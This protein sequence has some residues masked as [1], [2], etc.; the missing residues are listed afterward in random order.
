MHAE[1]RSLLEGQWV[2]WVSPGARSISRV[3]SLVKESWGQHMSSLYLGR[4]SQ[5][6]RQALQAR[7]WSQQNGR[8]FI[9]EKP[10]DLDLDELDI[11]HIIP[12][13]DNG[14]D[15]PSNFALTLASYNRS[16][17]AAD[18]RIA[19]VLARFDK[20]KESADFDDRGANLDDILNAFGGAQSNLRVKI[21]A[22]SVTYVASTKG[23]EEK[24]TVPLYEDKLSEIAPFL[25]DAADRGASPRRTY[26]PATDRRQLAW[27]R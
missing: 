8:C 20:I 19:R 3:I 2:L 25:R 4:L 5:Q 12:T 27:S 24:V 26:K 1:G 13:R 9:S 7:L 17:Q 14:K 15:D 18:L 11:D 6:E 10:I 23:G 16:K 22:T 21:D